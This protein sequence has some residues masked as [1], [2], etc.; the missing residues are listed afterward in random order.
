VIKGLE[1]KT[2]IVDSHKEVLPYWLRE[3]QKLKQPLVAV[4]IDKHHDMSDDCSALP[5]SEGRQN[6]GYL[7]KIAPY[8]SHYTEREINEANFTCPAFH[9]GIMGALYH[10]NP[11]LETIDAYGRVF[12]TRFLGNPKTKTKATMIS[13]KRILRLFWDDKLTKLRVQGGKVVPI[14][15]KLTIEE[16]KSDISQGRFPVVIGFD[17]DGICAIEEKKLTE[18]TLSSRLDKTKKVLD[19]IPS[20]VFA[21]IARSQTPRAYVPP[22]LVDHLQETI[23]SLIEKIFA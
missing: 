10:F 20:P 3:Y 16:F 17:L 23:V 21:C 15:E 1:M 18:E 4:R 14:P 6:F 7:E 12:G 5:A 2:I 9:Y 22:A 13:G 11:R 8:I 19:C